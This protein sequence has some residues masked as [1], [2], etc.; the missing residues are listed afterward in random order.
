MHHISISPSLQIE[1]IY[2]RHKYWLIKDPLINC[3]RR[4]ALFRLTSSYEI[5]KESRTRSSIWWE[6]C[7]MT[8]W[9]RAD[10]IALRRSLAEWKHTTSANCD[11]TSHFVEEKKWTKVCKKQ[12][13]TTT[14]WRSWK[15]HKSHVI[16]FNTLA[17]RQWERLKEIEEAISS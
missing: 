5:Q 12:R 15:S 10:Q 6:N 11:A 9:M 4:A 3:R 2:S 16:K 14:E 1:L 8:N 17:R 13:T 7:S